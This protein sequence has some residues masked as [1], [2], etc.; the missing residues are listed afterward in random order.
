MK[1]TNKEVELMHKIG[2][3]VNF[4]NPSDEEL[5]EIEER[6]EEYETLH[7]LDAN[8]KLN[9]EGKICEGIVDKL[10]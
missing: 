7:C 5:V 3:G 2:I 4:E 6:V 1:F 8:Y 9:E 10:L